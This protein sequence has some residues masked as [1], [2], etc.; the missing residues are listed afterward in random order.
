M[1]VQDNTPELT[2]TSPSCRSCEMA[3][4]IVTIC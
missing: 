4:A 2:H 1:T 3:G